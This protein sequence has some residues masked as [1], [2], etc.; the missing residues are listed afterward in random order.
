MIGDKYDND[1]VRWDLLLWDEV[2]DVAKVLTYGAKKY[3]DYN[4]IAVPEAQDRYFAAAHRH[5]KAWRSDESLDSGSGLPHL[6]HAVCCLLFLMWFD[7]LEEED[8]NDC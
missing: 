7:A 5:I 6:A 8:D 3:E 2:E 4:W 1:K